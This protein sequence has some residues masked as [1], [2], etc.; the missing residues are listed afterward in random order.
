MRHTNFATMHEFYEVP[1]RIIEPVSPTM[2]AL[3][4][5][6]LDL[7]GRIRRHRDAVDSH[8][9][10]VDGVSRASILISTDLI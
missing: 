1:Q 9:V 7:Q 2:L 5:H 3:A 4:N 10:N 6:I 8:K